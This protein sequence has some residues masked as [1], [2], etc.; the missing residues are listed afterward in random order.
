MK[1]VNANNI[2]VETALVFFIMASN[3]AEMPLFPAGAPKAIAPVS[4]ELTAQVYQAQ[5][6]G[7]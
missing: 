6:R 5:P 7:R 4:E 2:R 3:S 1:S